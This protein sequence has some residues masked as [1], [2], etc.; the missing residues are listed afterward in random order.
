MMNSQINALTWSLFVDFAPGPKAAWAAASCIFSL[1]TL[2][3]APIADAP[4]IALVERKQKDVWRWAVIGL[5]GLLLE[6][7]FEANQPDAKRAAEAAVQLVD[8]HSLN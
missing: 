5:N 7:G 4:V 8:V 6:E 2:E 3:I 1:C